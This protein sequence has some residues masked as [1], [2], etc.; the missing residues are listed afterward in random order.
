VTTE[1]VA[2]VVSDFLT[3]ANLD[4]DKY[5]KCMDGSYPKERLDQDLSE[6]R[7]YGV[8]ATPTVFV[9]GRKYVGFRDE[10]AFLTAINTAAQATEKEG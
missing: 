3:E 1:T 2:S 7:S 8:Y 9:N 5:T 4:K 6:A 10:A